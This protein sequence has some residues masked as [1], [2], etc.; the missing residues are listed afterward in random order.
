MAL[1]T[2]SHGD[3]YYRCELH[4]NHALG[5][6]MSVTDLLGKDE[7]VPGAGA[8]TQSVPRAE[9]QVR[10]TRELATLP[11]PSPVGS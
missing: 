7:P 10:P 5:Q 9:R 4:C 11:G 8:L 1:P 3:P 6:G 2:Q